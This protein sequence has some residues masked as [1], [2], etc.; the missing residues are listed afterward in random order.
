VGSRL[1]LPQLGLGAA[2]P[3]YSLLPYGVGPL[4]EEPRSRSFCV[5]SSIFQGLE[6][7]LVHDEGQSRAGLVILVNE[8]AVKVYTAKTIE[9]IICE[10]KT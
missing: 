10:K 2:G 7:V 6:Q 4:P 9:D 3:D 5:P 1:Q 8:R